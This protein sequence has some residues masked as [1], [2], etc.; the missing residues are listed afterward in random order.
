MELLVVYIIYLIVIYVLPLVAAYSISRYISKKTVIS[1]FKNRWLRFF[2]T[3]IIF[4]MCIVTIYSLVF[5]L[6]P[7]FGR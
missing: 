7:E 3:V 5:M 6:F 2:L 4:L 1:T